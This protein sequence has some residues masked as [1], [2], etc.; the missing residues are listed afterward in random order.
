MNPGIMMFGSIL[1]DWWVEESA[2]DIAR[3][4]DV[5]ERAV[6]NVPPIKQKRFWKR[7]IYFWLKYSMYEELHGHDNIEDRVR[8]IFDKAIEIVPHKLFSFAKL[9]SLYADFEVRS[10]N[11]ER[12]RKIFGRALGECPKEKLFVLY[13][14]LELQL[15]NI[16]R[17]RKIC[18]KWIEVEPQNHKSW[19]K[20]VELENSVDEL[21]RARGALELALELD[22]SD[23]P[24]NIWRYYIDLEIEH[25]ETENARKL[26]E[27][28]LEKTQHYKV[29]KAYSD[30]ESKLSDDCAMDRARELIKRGIAVCKANNLPED[31]ALL[32]EHWLQI[33]KDKGDEDG[34]EMVTKKM[35]RKV[36][37]KREVFSMSGESEGLE[38]YI[39]YIFPD[40]DG[41]PQNLKILEMA[42]AWKKKKLEEK[43]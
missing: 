13:E 30:F 24:E 14:E 16:E 38:E 7:Y 35:P 21:D 10:L 34:V 28:L 6:A 40:D 42:A 18:L 1:L 26:Y 8:N 27:R 41:Q 20:L 23:I 31:R 5:Y 2:G 19:L 36:K 22:T 32:V 29:F 25:G 3:V 11:L 43:S 9:W 37:R 4:R 39:A 17:A 12:A 33:E 15:G